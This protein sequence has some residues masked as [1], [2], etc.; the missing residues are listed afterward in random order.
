MQ[1]R[2]IGKAANGI[3]VQEPDIGNFIKCISNGLYNLKERDCTL[4]GT[5]LLE[6]CRV[7]VIS[8]DIHKHL[9]KLHDYEEERRDLLSDDKLLAQQKVYILLFHTIVVTTSS[10]WPISVSTRR[11]SIGSWQEWLLRT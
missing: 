10:A 9:Q 6:P 1:K 5:G 8:S 11:Y 3:A 4:G 7:C 2:I